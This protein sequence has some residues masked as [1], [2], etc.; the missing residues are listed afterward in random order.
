MHSDELIVKSDIFHCMCECTSSSTESLSLEINAG[1][2]LIHVH[3]C[4]HCKRK[5]ARNFFNFGAAEARTLA[6][7]VCK[8][9]ANI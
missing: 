3:A 8:T 5:I 6:D 1:F 9:S 7:A 4:M 2:L